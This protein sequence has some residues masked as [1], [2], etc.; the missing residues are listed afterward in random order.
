MEPRN[1][2][3]RCLSLT[4]LF[5]FSLLILIST[6]PANAAGDLKFNA[7]II[8]DNY[9]NAIRDLGVGFSYTAIETPEPKGITG[10]QAGV[11]V[12]GFELD[13]NAQYL[14]NSFSD[15]DVPNYAVLPKIYL[16]K[17]LPMNVD[18]EGF[19]ATR[20]GGNERLYGGAVKWSYWEGSTV[21]P[22]IGIRA[23]GTQLDGVDRL[24]LQTY[25]ADVSIS[26]GFAFITPYA[27]YSVF[28]IDGE[29]K[30]TTYTNLTDTK[31]STTENKAFGGF[32]FTVGFLN[33]V[34]QVDLGEVDSYSLRAN[35]GF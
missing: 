26:K 10:F 34:A 12:T 4:S 9:E 2:T 31:Y 5:C 22:S 15:S 11:A 21:A 1:S 7:D 14:E 18:V 6:S 25:G 3:S 30:G 23:H 17:G 35:V 24:D 29:A 28:E 13:D 19:I 32:R 27:G 33:A 8:Q 20:P 16:S